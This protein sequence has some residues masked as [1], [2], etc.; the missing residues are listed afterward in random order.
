[1]IISKWTENFTVDRA[2]EVFVWIRF[3][4][5]PM[6]YWG[7]DSLSKLASQ[8]GR[9]VEMDLVTK[10][11]EQANFARVRV[12]MRIGI[13]LQEQV[14]YLDDADRVIIQPVE[15]EWKPVTCSK[16]LMFGHL[17]TECRTKKVVTQKWVPKKPT[18]EQEW[19]TVSKKKDKGKDPVIADNTPQPQKASSSSVPQEVPPKPV[20]PLPVK[21]N[22]P[23]ANKARSQGKSVVSAKT[24][25]TDSHGMQKKAEGVRKD[26]EL[27]DKGPNS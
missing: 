18:D 5:L 20:G 11:K 8:L 23:P 16:C 25:S 1:M 17:E 22:I 14:T 26:A 3:P 2:P 21:K 19:I 6:K 27:V 4:K 12:R 10:Q 13:S 24:T 9:P 7:R 15:Y